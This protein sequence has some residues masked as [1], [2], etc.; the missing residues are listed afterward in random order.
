MFLGIAGRYAGSTVYK[1][2]PAGCF[3]LN[4]FQRISN[5]T[6]A[7]HTFRLNSFEHPS[8]TLRSRTSKSTSKRRFIQTQ[9]FQSFTP[10]SPESLGKAAPAKEYRHTI[11]WGRRLLYICTV[12]GVFYLIDPH[13]YASSITRSLRT[14][15]LGILVA[16]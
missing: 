11:K 1:C 4:T 13:H 2:R 9:Q 5:R 7:I 14:F 12:T 16:L 3:P 10:P 15:G 6:F 8:T